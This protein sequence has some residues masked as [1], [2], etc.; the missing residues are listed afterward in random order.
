VLESLFDGAGGRA[1]AGG[2]AE[3][4]DLEAGAAEDGAVE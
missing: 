4:A 1:I 3:A 2:E